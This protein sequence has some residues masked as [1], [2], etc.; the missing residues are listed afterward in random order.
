MQPED[1]NMK[2]LEDR[3]RSGADLA[4]DEVSALFRADAQGR[5]ED[6]SVV[7][8]QGS[9]ESTMHATIAG[10]QTMTRTPNGLDSG[11]TAFTAS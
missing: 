2:I 4:R 11:G 3:K 6:R 5:G 1:P 10:P 8:L 7:E 9:G